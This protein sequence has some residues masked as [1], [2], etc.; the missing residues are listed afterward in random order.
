VEATSSAARKWLI[1]NGRRLCIAVLTLF[2]TLAVS[3][4]FVAVIVIVVR[5]A[6]F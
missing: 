1:G 6:R 2:A 3:G 4:M 5:H